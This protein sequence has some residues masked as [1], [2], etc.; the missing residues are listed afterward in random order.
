MGRLKYFKALVLALIDS[1]KC[2]VICNKYRILKFKTIQAGI[3]EF[4]VGKYGKEAFNNRFCNINEKYLE[5]Y[6]AEEK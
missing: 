6:L 2:L 3:L 1:F 5:E 4:I